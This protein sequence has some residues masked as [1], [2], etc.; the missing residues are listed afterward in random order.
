M[1]AGLNERATGSAV[2]GTLSVFSL[3]YFRYVNAN[4]GQSAAKQLS[5]CAVLLPSYRCVRTPE[6]LSGHASEKCEKAVIPGC[7]D[8]NFLD[9]DCPFFNNETGHYLHS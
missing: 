9:R 2:P 1:G 6:N 5:L 3:I 4:P 8:L 7:S